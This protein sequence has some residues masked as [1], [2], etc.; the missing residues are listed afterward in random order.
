MERGAGYE[1]TAYKSD[2]DTWNDY[3]NRDNFRNE[4]FRS[5]GMNSANPDYMGGRQYP[6]DRDRS[7]NE[8]FERGRFN[9]G[10]MVDRR[11]YEPSYLSTIKNYRP[12]GG[13]RIERSQMDEDEM[14]ANTYRPQQSPYRRS[15]DY[16]E[17]AGNYNREDDYRWSER[18]RPSEDDRY[19]ERRRY[20][21]GDFNS[22]Y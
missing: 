19:R 11:D 10:Y 1:H 15:Y 7:E 5:R 13:R 22:Y 12:E 6:S 4:R 9:R 21:G 20:A 14:R 16:H 3:R 18:R 8:F 2:L 17:E